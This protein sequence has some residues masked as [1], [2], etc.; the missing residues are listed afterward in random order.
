MKNLSI[1]LAAAALVVSAAAAVP[2]S[3]APALQTPPPETV[4]AFFEALP[5][6][7]LP[8][9][10]NSRDL[11]VQFHKDYED[12]IVDPSDFEDD[13]EFYYGDMY[14]EQISWQIFWNPEI[15]EPYWDAEEEEEGEYVPQPSLVFSIYPGSDP[16]RIFGLLEITEFRPRVGTIKLGEHSYWYSVSKNTV[17]PVALP[18]DVT[19]T[20]DEITDDG[21]L[22]YNQNELYWVMRDRRMEWY[23]EQDRITLNLDGIGSTPVSYVWNGTKFVRDRSYN[24]LLVYSG[25]LGR[26]GFGETVPFGIHG[27]DAFWFDTDEENVRAW[28][29]VKEGEEKERFVIYSYGNGPITVDA[30]DVLYPNYKLFEKIHVGMPASE[31]MEAFKEFYGYMDEPPTPYVSAFDGKAWIFSGFDDPYMLGVDLKYYKNNKL[32][33]DAKI[34]VIKIAPAVG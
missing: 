27:Y 1:L 19:Y 20:D 7:D 10:I 17:T 5:N 4:W 26:I 14:M 24:P 6:A 21:M 12:Q 23:E 9:G 25:G 8:A 18:L 28:R 11:R 16:D 22:L 15:L 2:A 13:E 3:A 34:A 33:P 30:I 29:Y 31:A 32:T